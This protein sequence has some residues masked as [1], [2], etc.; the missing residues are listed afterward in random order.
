ARGD[1]AAAVLAA[2][3]AEV[4]R[5]QVE[6]DGGDV[7]ELRG[8]EALCV[9][10]SPRAS[11]RCAVAMQQRFANE[12]R[13]RPDL[14]LRV[15]I[16]IDAG[17]AVPVGDGF[18]GGAL[19]LAARLC[20]LAKPGEVLVSE[21]VV[22][23]ARRVEGVEYLDQGRVDLKGLRD[24]VRYYRTRFELDLPTAEAAGGWRRRRV[25]A[26]AAVAALIL[27]AGVVSLE[28]RSGSAA[29]IV[30]GDNAI[31]QLDTSGRVVGQASF[32]D[33]P[34]GVAVGLGQVWVTNTADDAL[35]EIDPASSQP[36]GSPIPVG[37]SPTGVAVAGGRVWV[38]DGGDRRVVEYDPRSGKI[39]KR[40]P[41]GNGAGPIATGHGVVWV[42]NSADGS[43]QRIDTASGRVS[44]PISVGAA[45]SAVAVGGGAA[46]VTDEADGLLARIDEQTLQVTRV[47]VGQTPAAVAFGGNAVW[48]AN[49]TDN[50]VTRVRLPSLQID[51]I[52]VAAPSGIAFGASG[53]WVASRQAASLTRIDPTSARVTAT[54]HTGG[55]P[56]SLVTTADGVWTT[57][58]SAASSH[59]GGTLRLGLGVAF[60]SVDP[61]VSF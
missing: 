59:S 1:E 4:V 26:V 23:F 2:R 38:V 52:P 5:E 13:S 39:L 42:V 58:L 9:F 61:A 36:A 50:A 17:E 12:I 25:A 20:A 32:A 6:G 31:G 21:G 8:D 35:R 16:G 10:D 34:G 19:N 56:G 41:V 28:L 7:V 60:D 15:G 37:S 54:I 43:V 29:P 48:V 18:R 14:P 33:P 22:M 46:W 53:V 51:K 11:I 49:T 27:A 45:P 44:P 24:P 55:P 30:M 57:T 3:F 40:V 47:P